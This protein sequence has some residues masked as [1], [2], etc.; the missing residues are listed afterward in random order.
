MEKEN[1]RIKIEKQGVLL[2]RGHITKK[3]NKWYFVVDIGKIDGKRKQKWSKGYDKKKLAEE[4]LAEFIQQFNAGEYI[5]N[6][7]ITVA[8]YLNKWFH[9]YV[10]IKLAPRTQIRYLEI[11]NNYFIPEFGR[12]KLSDLKPYH[13]QSHYS[14]VIEK[15]SASTVLYHHRVIH[16][17]LKQA[18]KWQFIS[19]NPADNVEPPSANKSDFTV[20]SAEHIDKLIQYLKEQNHILYIPVL[21]AVMT[22]MRRGEI[23]GLQWPDIDF[24][25]GT[26]QIKRQLQRING[27]LVLRETKTAGSRRPISLDDITISLL[28]EYRQEQKKNRVLFGPE[29]HVENFGFVC[30]WPDGKLLDP[31]YISHVFPRLLKELNLPPVR[32]HDLRHTS[33]TMLLEAGVNPKVVSERLGHTDIR[34]TLNTYSHVLPNMQK[35]AAEKLAEKL[36]SKSR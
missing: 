24:N 35:E 14:K 28:K 3:N 16:K 33:A 8:E 18:V 17:A 19:H 13:L 6:K 32:F 20:L 2:L 15:L 34:I 29:Y 26:L 10:E 31:D 36:F 12:I 21:L 30:T 22:G 9:D 7:G 5:D 4:A 27:E 23:C 25:T 11:I 1:K